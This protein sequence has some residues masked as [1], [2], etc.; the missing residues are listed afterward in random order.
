MQKTDCYARQTS[1][2]S[3]ASRIPKE[4]QWS[5]LNNCY[6]KGRAPAK[7]TAKGISQQRNAAHTVHPRGFNKAEICCNNG[8][9]A[10]GLLRLPTP[11][12]IGLR[13]H[14]RNRKE[15]PLSRRQA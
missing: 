1:C 12:N 9:E 11:L 8:A 14:G 13:V 5:S 3:Q 2:A 15:R 6:S 7:D 10:N 4:T